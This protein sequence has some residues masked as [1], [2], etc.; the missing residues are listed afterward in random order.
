MPIFWCLAAAALFGASTPA[1]KHLLGG[2]GPI[3]LAGLLY[4]GAAIAVLP[5]TLRCGSRALRRK[6]RNVLMLLG[7]VVLMIVGLLAT[8]PLLSGFHRRNHVAN[9]ARR[10]SIPVSYRLVRIGHGLSCG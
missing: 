5:F 1:S 8:R 10:A 6:R 7:A 4:L 9:L 2:L 3:A